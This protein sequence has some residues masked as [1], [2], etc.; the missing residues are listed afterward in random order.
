MSLVALINQFAR[1]VMQETQKIPEV[2]VLHKWSF[3]KL[4]AESSDRLKQDPI[5]VPGAIPEIQIETGQGVVKVRRS[6]PTPLAPPDRSSG[7]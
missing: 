6:E 4:V 7:R 1:D 2:I 3:D 5:Y